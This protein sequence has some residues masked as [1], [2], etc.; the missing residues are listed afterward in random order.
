MKP[1]DEQ[2]DELGCLCSRRRL[3]RRHR[4][5]LNEIG[6]ELVKRWR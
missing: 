6:S 5:L 3:G 2:K 1:L 4:L